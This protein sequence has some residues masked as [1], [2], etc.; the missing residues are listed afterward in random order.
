MFHIVGNTKKGQPQRD[1]RHLGADAGAERRQHETD[2]RR[3]VEEELHLE[4]HAI[5]HR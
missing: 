4:A 3:Q 2:D 5:V 1:E